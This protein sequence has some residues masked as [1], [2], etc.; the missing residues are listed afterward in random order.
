MYFAARPPTEDGEANSLVN[1]R[2]TNSELR[3]KVGRSDP[4]ATQSIPVHRLC[5]PS[6]EC[7]WHYTPYDTD[8]SISQAHVPDGPGPVSL[9][10]D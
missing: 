9:C 2:S 7:T 5:Q 1:Q 4:G 10:S 6:T 8:Q 3:T